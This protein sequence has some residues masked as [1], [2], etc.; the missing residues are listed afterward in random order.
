MTQY[1]GKVIRKTP[2]T[3]TQQSASGVWKLNEQAAAIR[4]NS[5]PV[6]GVPDPI[7]RS[8]RFRSSASAYLNRTPSV[9]GSST[10]WTWSGWVKRGALGGAGAGIFY[11]GAFS[12]SSDETGLQFRGDDTIQIFQNNGATN[13]LSK[14]TSAVY[15]DPS[16]WYHIVCTF[17]TTNA[18]AEDRVRLYVNGVRVTSFST[19]TNISQNGTTYVNST[20]YGNRIFRDYA[21][22]YLDG[23]LTEVNFI[24]GQALTPSSFGTT[25]TRTGAWIP[26][27]YTGTYGTNGFYLNF[28]DPTSTTTIGYDYSGNSNNWTANNI[29]L[30]AGATYDSM[31]D[32]PTPWVG[33]STT[34]DTSAV[35]R[36][37]YAVVNP[38]D[39]DPSVTVSEGNLAHTTGASWLCSR[40][41]FQLPS[42]GKWYW[43]AT[44][45]TTTSSTVGA[46]IGVCTASAVLNNF[47]TTGQ[48]Q[49]QAAATGNL[50]S[51]GTQTASTLGVFTAGDII[52][53]AAD[54]DNGKIWIGKNNVFWNST[55]GT[56]GNPSGNSNETFA[57]S[58]A[59]MFPFTATY[60]DT[61]RYNFGQRPLSYTPP[62]GFKTLVT[63]NLP[64]PTITNGANYM[65]ATTYTGNGANRSISNAVN[66]VSFQPDFVWVKNRTN[67][68]DHDTYDSLRP[69]GSRLITNLTNAEGGTT[70]VQVNSFNSDGFGLGTYIGVNESG[71][72]FVGWQWQAGAGSSSSNTSGSI[73]STVSVNQTAGFS[74]VTYTGTGVVATVGHGLG[75][76]PNMVIVKRRDSSVNGDWFT[77][78]SMTGNSN[79]LFLNLTNG[80]TAGSG[81]WNNT[82]PTSSVFTVGTST[83]VN[84]SAST[85]V[86]YCW[87][88]VAGYSAFGSYTGNGSTDGTFVYLGFRPRFL[89]VKRTDTTS[90]WVIVDSSRNVY[91]PQDLNLYPNLSAA[92]D[93]Y[94]TTYPFDMLS[95]GVKFRANYANVNASGGTYIYAA[96]A[97]NPFKFSN[98]R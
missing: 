69:Q 88:S 43:E 6:P 59:G 65:A 57:T 74:V 15:R 14:I 37:N 53:V 40:G 50:Y 48:Y 19:N 52:Q 27:P 58:P 13:V 26:M 66:G 29:S 63:T 9:A 64:T 10:T 11:A 84:A 51:N 54:C 90:N 42:S 20:S 67:A 97:E 81:S 83:G 70:T 78:T 76:A 30:T 80:S 98:A 33:Y 61:V 25:D 35:T 60:Q 72:A 56:T 49:A 75:V 85:Y 3:P 93:D 12:T 18:T 5:W 21:T 62:T 77:Y 55:G 91:N 95:N 23:Y 47:N 22:G 34:T 1:S 17:D 94:T 24:D 68:Y 46:S 89:M 28:K 31:L 7:S 73:T 32:V 71:S 2:V 38:L 92:E 4:N 45:G 36:G 82:S 86:A 87:A 96:F 16:A 44:I 39:K 8:L 79:T 41:S